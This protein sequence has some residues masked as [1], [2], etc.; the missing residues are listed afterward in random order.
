MGE[1]AR[2][3]RRAFFVRDF[4]GYSADYPSTRRTTSN[5]SSCRNGLSKRLSAP[6]RIASSV[7]FRR[8][9]TL[10]RTQLAVIAFLVNGPTILIG[11]AGF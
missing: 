11:L 3:S 9:R 8:G 5:N 10:L 6:L 7:R 4:D 2:H 1:E